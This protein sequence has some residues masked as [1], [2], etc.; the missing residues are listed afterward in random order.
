MPWACLGDFSE[1][2]SATEKAGG[3]DRSQQQMEGFREVINIC[4]FQ[5]MEPKTS[6]GK[7][8]TKIG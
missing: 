2:L 7:N 3:P 1:I 5:D 4:N 8:P 6:E